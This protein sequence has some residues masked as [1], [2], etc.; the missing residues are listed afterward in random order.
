[1][2]FPCLSSWFDFFFSKHSH[3]LSPKMLCFSCYLSNDIDFCLEWYGIYPLIFFSFFLRIVF[4]LLIL[5]PFA[6]YAY[7]ILNDI[8]V[9]QNIVTVISSVSTLKNFDINDLNV[10]SFSQIA[11]CGRIKTFCE[12][13]PSLVL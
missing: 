8:H 10:L 9:N 4:S 12:L 13:E 2:L 7:V 11:V 5:N 6:G 3:P 1:M